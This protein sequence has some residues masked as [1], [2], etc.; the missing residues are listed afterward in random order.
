MKPKGARERGFTLVELLV[1][2]AIIAI[3][4][5]LLLP[6]LWSAK[7]KAQSLR[8]M[9]NLR[10]ITDSYQD[11]VEADEG[12]LWPKYYANPPYPFESYAGSAQGDW[13]V[14]NWGMP[15]KNWI[16]PNAPERPP[17][18]WEKPAAASPPDVFS[19]S[20]DSAWVFTQ[21]GENYWWFWWDL[22][23]RNRNVYKRVGSYAANN[24]ITGGRYFIRDNYPFEAEAFLD[25]TQFQDAARTPVFADGSGGWWYWG[26][27]GWGPHAD[28]P[29]GRDLVTGMD[30]MRLGM[31]A[32]NL[33]RHGSR[34]ARPT[35]N[36]PDNERLPGAI[37]LSFYDGHIENV[38]LENLWS[39]Y[40]H[41]NYIPPRRRPG[42]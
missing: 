21:G 38:K 41:K 29:P 25:E 40:W 24:W 1:V 42:L 14:N 16:C 33:P 17:S 26:G 7:A 10:Y 4:A 27:Y 28:D 13:F 19:G 5:S 18:R 39:L 8:C 11:A 20:V 6:A 23:P 36:H 9:T 30:P 37:N 2:V 35:R 32:F 34:P 15:G 31:G 3:L 22:D 12:K